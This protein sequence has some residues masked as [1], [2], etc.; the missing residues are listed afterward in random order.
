M[1]GRV[2]VSVPM[3]DDELEHL[4]RRAGEGLVDSREHWHNRGAV[5][6]RSYAHRRG[7][8]QTCSQASVGDKLSE[9]RREH[10]GVAR[11]DEQSRTAF[12]DRLAHA[13]DVARDD[14]QSVC[15]RFKYRE[16]KPLP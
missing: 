9:P 10:V 16:W 8:S 4:S 6:V 12:D 15:P 7:P 3:Q 2:A 14:R 11:S 13:T 1:I 5:E